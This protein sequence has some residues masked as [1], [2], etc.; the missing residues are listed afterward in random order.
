MRAHLL[1]VAAASMAA[2]ASAQNGLIGISGSAR[3]TAFPTSF[4]PGTTSVNVFEVGATAIP[5]GIVA[6][7]QGA[8]AV[9]TT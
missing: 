9:A 1:G 3:V 4:A 7:V 2:L 6:S 5:Q 8:N